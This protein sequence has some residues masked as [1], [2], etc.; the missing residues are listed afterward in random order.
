MRPKFSVDPIPTAS[1]TFSTTGEICKSS[2]GQLRMAPCL[3]HVGSS[4]PNMCWKHPRGSVAPYRVASHCFQR[5]LFTINPDDIPH[6]SLG[7]NGSSI[8]RVQRSCHRQ[9]SFPL[10][11]VIPHV[12]CNSPWCYS[13][14]F[15]SSYPYCLPRCDR[16]FQHRVLNLCPFALPLVFSWNFNVL[17]C[18]CHWSHYTLDSSSTICVCPMCS[19]TD[20]ASAM[21]DR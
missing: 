8:A 12:N 19:K 17:W 20:E 1:A 16:L 15:T 21:D 18:I 14:P 7:F 2:D 6:A 9:V 13:R 4:F 3:L 5:L 10:S 11:I